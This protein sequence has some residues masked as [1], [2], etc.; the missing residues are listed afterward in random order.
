MVWFSST[1]WLSEYFLFHSDLTKLTNSHY[2]KEKK[3]SAMSI[4]PNIAEQKK[5]IKVNPAKRR[6]TQLPW[7]LS[8]SVSVHLPTGP[9]P[10]P[11]E[12]VSIA[13]SLCYK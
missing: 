7:P 11:S 10:Q 6:N 9:G 5:G 13:M 8:L 1:F 2:K 4:L 3:I 12:A